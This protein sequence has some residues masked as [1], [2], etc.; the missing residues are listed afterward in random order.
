M[1]KDSKSHLKEVNE[2]YTEHLIAAFKIG[3]TMI[4]GGFQAILHAL[5]PGILSK[6]AS[7][8]IKKLY[9]IVSRRN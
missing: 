5:I 4:L 9:E 7:D 2:K 1:I 6:S 3:I 8:K